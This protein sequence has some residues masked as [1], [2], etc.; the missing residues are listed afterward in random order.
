MPHAPAVGPAGAVKRSGMLEVMA[1]TMLTLRF[2]NEDLLILLGGALFLVLKLSPNAN[3]AR[4]TRQARA[5]LLRQ[6]L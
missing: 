4:I 1:P 5:S 2:E 6:M 3:L